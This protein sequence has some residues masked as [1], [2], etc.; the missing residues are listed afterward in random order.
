MEGARE[1]RYRQ[2]ANKSQD[3]TTRDGTAKDGKKQ[4]KP[5]GNGRQLLR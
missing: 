1:R 2:E 4:L 3:G 5:A